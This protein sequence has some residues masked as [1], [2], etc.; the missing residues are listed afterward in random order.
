MMKGI[1]IAAVEARQELGFLSKQEFLAP[2]VAMKDLEGKG[3]NSQRRDGSG[4][5]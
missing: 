1:G 2:C 4:A 3:Q 5:G